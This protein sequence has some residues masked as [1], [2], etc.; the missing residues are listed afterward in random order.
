MFLVSA[1][2]PMTSYLNVD[3]SPSAPRWRPSGFCDGKYCFANASLMIT[4]LGAP[5]ASRGEN[6]RPWTRRILAVEKKPGPTTLTDGRVQ[7]G[8]A[9]FFFRRKFAPLDQE[10]SRSRKETWPHHVEPGHLSLLRRLPFDP[11]RSKMAARP[12]REVPAQGS[13]HHARHALDA[14]YK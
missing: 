13:G 1:A 10:D 12:E 3:F 8:G 2:T 6:S 9:G 5:A 14:L 7:R 11:N 4:T